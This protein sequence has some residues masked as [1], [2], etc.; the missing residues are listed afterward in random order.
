MRNIII[1]GILVIMILASGCNTA[2]TTEVI[3][4][5]DSATTITAHVNQEFIIAL[6]SNETTGYSWLETHE[7]SKLE[8]VKDEYQPKETAPY[9]VG[10]GGTHYFTFKALKKGETEITL[11]YCRSW[12]QE[13]IADKPY[14]FTENDKTESFT[15]KIK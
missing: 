14:T 8:L 4:Y 15:V 3:T 12:E 1:T 2:D 5:T 13:S 9:V 6:E 10:V 11:V 7:T